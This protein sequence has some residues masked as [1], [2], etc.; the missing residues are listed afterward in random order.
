MVKLEQELKHAEKNRISKMRIFFVLLSVFSVAAGIIIG[1]IY[2]MLSELP[3]IKALEAYKPIESSRV[4]SS[5]GELL[6]ELYLE[7]RTFI[8]HYRIPEHVKK[9]F[10]SIEDIRFY[11]HHGVDVIGIMRALYHDVKAGSIVQGGS[12]ITQQLAKMLFLKPD[13]SIK[14]KVREAVISIQIEKR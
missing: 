11:K 6:A 14:R 7:R 9:A 13:R 3:Q 2:W 10:V 4:Y 1:S 5:E 12:T 8:P